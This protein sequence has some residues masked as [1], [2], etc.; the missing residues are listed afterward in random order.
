MK[1]NVLRL[2]LLLLPLL[3]AIRF[4]ASSQNTAK[5]ST[6]RKGSSE[7]S[8]SSVIPGETIQCYYSENQVVVNKLKPDEFDKA[9]VYNMQGAPVLRHRITAATIRMD[10]TPLNEGVYLLVLSSTMSLREKSFKV[11]VHRH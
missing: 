9:A 1:K 8:L 6:A 10:A 7:T 3:L 11:V 5:K 2:L 4:S